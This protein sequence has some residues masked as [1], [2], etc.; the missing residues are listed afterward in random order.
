MQNLKHSTVAV[1]IMAL[2]E[3]LLAARSLEMLNI[4]HTIKG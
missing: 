1:T 4:K 2:S 3:G